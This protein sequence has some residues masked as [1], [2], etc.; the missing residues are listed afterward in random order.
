M[1]TLTREGNYPFIFQRPLY[2]CN[3]IM[4]NLT[5]RG[6]LVE[7]PIIWGAT[8]CRLVK[9]SGRFE[10]R[11]AFHIHGQA[12]QVLEWPE[13][14]HTTIFRNI[15]N[16]APS[17]TEQRLRGLDIWCQ[18]DELVVVASIWRIK[19]IQWKYIS[20]CNDLSNSRRIIAPGSYMYWIF[21]QIT[22]QIFC[23]YGVC[24]LNIGV[25]TVSS[26]KAFP[27]PVSASSSKIFK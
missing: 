1:E 17:N 5:F 15:E 24:L 23:N 25:V 12:V 9:R 3:S 21:V 11:S 13:N 16:C 2:S 20:V 27:C 8:P 18:C 4:R 7:I 14:G 26:K 22:L 19:S 6:A 10:A